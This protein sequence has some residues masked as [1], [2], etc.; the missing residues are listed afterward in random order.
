MSKSG[1]S[2]LTFFG[3][4]ITDDTLVRNRNSSHHFG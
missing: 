2:E 3:R 4:T 1:F